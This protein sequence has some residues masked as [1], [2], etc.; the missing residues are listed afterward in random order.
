M[1]VFHHEHILPTVKSIIDF[2]T[3][4][5]LLM[6]VFYVVGKSRRYSPESGSLWSE[7]KIVGIGT[8]NNQS[9]LIDRGIDNV[10]FL[11]DV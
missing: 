7:I 5:K 1:C 9:N 3:Q 10:I 2:H 11:N 4:S 6:I 8:T